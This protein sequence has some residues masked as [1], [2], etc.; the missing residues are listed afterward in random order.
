ML[1]LAGDYPDYVMMGGI[2]K[3]MFEPGDPAQTG[4]FE[5]PDIRQAIDNELERVVAPMT[6][7]GGYIASLDHWAFWGTTF[8]GYK[9]YSESLERYG[10]ANLVTRTSI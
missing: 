9:H 1:E 10:K 3:H 8:E 4:R 6:K 2:Y 5:S 7:R